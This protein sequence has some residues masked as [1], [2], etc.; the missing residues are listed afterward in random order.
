MIQLKKMIMDEAS[1]SIHE[2]DQT[3]KNYPWEDRLMYANWLAQSYFYVCHTT[4][5]MAL[6]C[7][8]FTLAQNDFHNS[9]IEHIKEEKGHEKLAFND[10]KAMGYH[11]SQFTEYTET[12]CIYQSMNYLIM[13]DEPISILGFALVLEGLA[14]QKLTS[15]YKAIAQVHGAQAATFLKVHTI[16]DVE[17]SQE[18][19]H[20]LDLCSEQQL[21]SV[22]KAVRHCDTLYKNLYIKL[23]SEK[24]NIYQQFQNYK[25]TSPEI[26]A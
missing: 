2:I 14:A 8:R 20:T 23:M 21:K 10:L 3:V 11:P 13:N 9:F 17:H 7:S 19:E 4:R 22:L 24:E 15:T 6:A 1:K 18:S 26:T 25:I 12:A 5:N 16:V